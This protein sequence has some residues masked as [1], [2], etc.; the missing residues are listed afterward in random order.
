MNVWVDANVLLRYITKDVP[1]QARR[2]Q[3]LMRRAE[4]GELVL[5]VP[6]VVIA[7]VVWVLGSYYEFGPGQ[8]ADTV[9]AL[10]SADGMAV[11]DADLVLE[12]LR[13]M[14]HAGV[15]FADAFLAATARQRGQPL[16]TFDRDFQRLGVELFG[17]G[18]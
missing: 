18:G 6:N 13:V 10:V 7:E 14:E 9:R 5:H 15:S 12:A 3:R 4:D 8:I 17:V 11:D 16:A 1:E 2:A